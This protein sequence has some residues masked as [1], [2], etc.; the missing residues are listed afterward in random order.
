MFQVTTNGALTTVISFRESRGPNEL[1]G[2]ADGN[3]YGT[4]DNTIIRVT[5][6]VLTTLVSFTGE[7]LPTLTGWF[8]AVMAIS[9]ARPAVAATPALANR[10]SCHDQRGADHAR[11]F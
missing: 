4:L 2:G 7:T 11:L 3:L 6:G 1:V 5:N 9:T 8:G 10:F